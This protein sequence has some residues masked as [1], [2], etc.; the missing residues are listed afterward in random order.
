[1]AEQFRWNQMYGGRIERIP[2]ETNSAN[3]AAYKLRVASAKPRRY[4]TGEKPTVYVKKAGES[5]YLPRGRVPANIMSYRPFAGAVPREPRIELVGGTSGAIKPEAWELAQQAL[6]N[7]V[8][9]MPNFEVQLQKNNKGKEFF[10][11]DAGVKHPI[12]Q[13]V[14]LPPNRAKFRLKTHVYDTKAKKYVEKTTEHIIK[15]RR[16][17]TKQRASKK[18]TAAGIAPSR[19]LVGYDNSTFF[20]YTTHKRDEDRKKIYITPAGALRNA[21]RGGAPIPPKYIP[22]VL[23]RLVKDWA[24]LPKPKPSVYEYLASKNYQVPN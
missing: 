23:Q 7:S 2:A 20:G 1:M 24:A 8:R 5:G 11:N 13:N 14:R 18:V 22:A 10:I 19:A 16:F 4:E 6:G 12:I 15:V 21:T 3:E 17:Q 9:V